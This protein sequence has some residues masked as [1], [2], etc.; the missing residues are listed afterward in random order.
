[1]RGASPPLQVM[2]VNLIMGQMF[3]CTSAGPS[4]YTSNADAVGNGNSPILEARYVMP[5]NQ[6]INGGF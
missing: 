3:Y 1:M 6:L 4:I 5:Q 2:A